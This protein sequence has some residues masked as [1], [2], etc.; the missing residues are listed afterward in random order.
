MSMNHYN[1]F[2]TKAFKCKG[3]PPNLETALGMAMMDHESRIDRSYLSLDVKGRWLTLKRPKKVS[4]TKEMLQWI[5]DVPYGYEF[6][7][8]HLLK[9]NSPTPVYRLAKALVDVGALCET[10]VH[11]GGAFR[12]KTYI[13]SIPNREVLKRMLRNHER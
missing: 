1:S 5:Y 7:L 13:V 3:V 11:L 9:T 6:T 8:Q 12:P 4:K 10:S 2:L